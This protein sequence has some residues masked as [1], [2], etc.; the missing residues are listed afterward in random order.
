[1]SVI[2]R[3]IYRFHARRSLYLDDYVVLFGA[4][5]LCAAIGIIFHIPELVFLGDVLQ[6]DPSLIVKATPD[7]IKLLGTPF[8]LQHA[9]FGLTFTTVFAVKFSFLIFFKKLITRV[10]KIHT[11][12]WFV[13]GFTLVSW[14]F[15]VLEPLV[16]CAEPSK[17]VGRLEFF[18]T[19]EPSFRID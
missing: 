16:L 7:Q 5:C 10:T 14:L 9:F 17:S 19:T 2:A 3:L 15:L 1:M 18:K 6:S 13:G 8:A 11:Y 4:L 12:Y